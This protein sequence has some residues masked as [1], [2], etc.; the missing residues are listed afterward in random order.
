MERRAHAVL[1][2]A[3]AA[4]IRYVDAARSYGR[5]EA[6]VRS[7]LDARRLA[8]GA[9]VVGSKWGY[10]YTGGWQLA[11]ERHEVKDHSL[12]AL[13]E[14]LAESHAVLGGH[15]ALY[16]IHSATEESGVLE[17]AAVVD[18][19]ARVRDAG[20]RV[21]VSVSGPT[22]AVTVRRALA[23]RRGGE[24]V[25]ASVQATWNLL[26]RACEDAL[27]DAHAAGSTVIVKEALANGRLTPR[28]DA[29]EALEE[30]A[31][32]CRSSADAVALAS[33]LAQPF[34]DVVLVGA[35]TTSQ[36][37]SNLRALELGLPSGA[38]ERLASL[39]EDSAA[40]WRRRA[41]LPWR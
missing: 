30:V 3:Y 5:A 27:R 7:W 17:D 31:V 38:L 24:P 29:A 6:F 2:A 11:A 28:G 19:L 33:A 14:Q 22:Q 13:R 32:A 18:E 40:Y 26:E 20:L 4:G 37:E 15:L 36:L 12:A 16:Q 39:R 10:R 9:V 35:S 34:A 25:F 8:P 1:D 41:A 21:G 23:L